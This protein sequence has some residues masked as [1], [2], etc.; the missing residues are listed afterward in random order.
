[1]RVKLAF[2][3]F[4]KGDGNGK[5]SGRPRFRSK[6][7]YRSFTYSQMEDKDLQGN[8]INLPK[9]GLVKLVLHRSIPEGFKIKTAIISKRP[10]GWYVTLSLEDTSVPELAVDMKPTVDN[11]IGIDVGLEKFLADSEGEFEEI[12]QYFRKSEEKLGLLQ[13]KVSTKKKGSRAKKL[14][15]RKVARLHQK[16]ARLRLQFHFETA[17]K[18]LNKA[19]VVFV[20]DLTVKNM[21]R[22]CKPKQDETGRFLPNGQSAKAGLNK[23]I[24]DAGWAQFIDILTFKVRNALPLSCRRLPPA[25]SAAERAGLK[26]VKV[27]PKG[28]SQHCSICLN[29]VPK[30]LKDRWHSCPKC[31]LEV[32]RDTNSAVLIKKVG[33]GV[34]LTIKRLTRKGREARAMPLVG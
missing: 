31:G 27:N 23:N 25:G 8:R 5:H 12:P 6:G 17:K 3:R 2:D 10:D 15:N 18:I 9:I 28:T 21:S 34:V 22:R 1:M 16:V 24:A 33:L 32:D 14:L 29:E 30:T 26:V 13:Q 20:E 7:R 4:I 19:N 11:S